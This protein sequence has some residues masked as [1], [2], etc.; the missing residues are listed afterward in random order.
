MLS[1]LKATI[2]FQLIECKYTLHSS[3]MWQ[4]ITNNGVRLLPS[5]LPN[6][7]AVK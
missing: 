7:M 5:I 1:F 6:N 2:N 3:E 4:I